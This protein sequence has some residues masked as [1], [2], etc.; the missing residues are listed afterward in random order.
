MTVRAAGIFDL[1]RVTSY[2]SAALR[3][4]AWIIGCVLPAPLASGAL[5]RWPQLLP[6][7]FPVGSRASVYIDT[8]GGAVRSAALVHEGS[9]PEWTLLVLV[10]DPDPA[11]ADGAFRLLSSIC[12]LAARRG[13][14][15]V[16]G[17]VP[18]EVRARETFFQAGFYSY[19]RETWYVS[20]GERLGR[21]TGD[22]AGRAAR[23]SDAHDLFRL[24]ASTT[25]HAVQR[26][27]QLSVQD[28]D[29][30]RG[31]H[32]FDA[33][34]LISGNPLA[35]RRAGIL[36]ER[37]EERVRSVA[38]AFRG[39]ERHPHVLKV[40][41]SDGDVDRARDLLRAAAADLPA[42]RPLGSPVRSYEDHMARALLSEGFR[43][44]VT[45]ML[46]VKELAVRIEEPA[47]APVV[48]R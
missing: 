45:A 19:T 22:S 29:V 2:V 32:A 31:G 16:F 3:D 36:L 38:V 11:G 18:D 48:V 40:R 26:A 44:T 27:E 46:F 13:V 41:T 30:G 43:E 9:G 25:P 4:P 21:P 6:G 17:S 37:A 24:Y 42:G 12:A 1:P 15:R 8:S 23:S 20:A 28:F 10:A 39:L 47:L 35:M 33:P 34:H 5:A 7:L 14:H